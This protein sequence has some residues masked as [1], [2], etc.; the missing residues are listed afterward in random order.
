MVPGPIV[1]ACALD[2]VCVQEG[3]RQA[4]PL[5]PRVRGRRARPAALKRATRRS[6]ASRRATE[7]LLGLTSAQAFREAPLHRLH[8]PNHNACAWDA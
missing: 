2:V 7:D 4:R 5:P 6:L 1:T 8:A 3:V